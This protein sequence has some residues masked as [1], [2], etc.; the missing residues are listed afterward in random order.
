MTEF[1]QGS[2][3]WIVAGYTA[4]CGS[5]RSEPATRPAA[6][7]ARVPVI[8]APMKSITFALR[9]HWVMAVLILLWIP[10]SLADGWAERSYSLVLVAALFVGLAGIGEGMLAMLRTGQRWAAIAAVILALLHI[11]IAAMLVVLILNGSRTSV[12]DDL[13]VG[14]LL[15]CFAVIG[16]V[17][18][19]KALPLYR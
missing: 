18:L 8:I 11:A 13:F 6:T 4:F 14:I 10:I 9:A 19:V 7:G 17:V 2:D 12:L 16:I 3:C 15:A 5:F 1:G